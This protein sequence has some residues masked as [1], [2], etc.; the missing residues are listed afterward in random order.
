MNTKYALPQLYFLLDPKHCK[1][2]KLF[3]LSFYSLLARDILQ[4]EVVKRAVSKFDKVKAKFIF[5]EKGPNYDS[6]EVTPYEQVIMDVVKHE[7]EQARFFI[8]KCFFRFESYDGYKENYFHKPLN[9]EHLTNESTLISKLFL[10]GIQLTEEGLEIQKGIQQLVQKGNESFELMHNLTTDKS[11]DY[12]Q[13]LAPL[14]LLSE[15]INDRMLYEFYTILDQKKQ[16]GEEDE[17]KE[18][19]IHNALKIWETMAVDLKFKDVDFKEIFSLNPYY[20]DQG[21][22]MATLGSPNGYSF[23][24]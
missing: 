21:M 5:I 18:A 23:P 17:N 3:R 24:G 12:L 1:G 7:P 16:F 4:V 6:H 15:E 20:F 14:F 22:I 8:S 2:E 11:V 9:D 13:L 19:R 10:E